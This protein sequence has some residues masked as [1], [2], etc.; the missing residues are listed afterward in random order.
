MDENNH[1]KEGKKPRLQ[2]SWSTSPAEI[3]KMWSREIDEL[4]MLSETQK[5][6]RCSRVVKIFLVAVNIFILAGACAILG[7][8]IWTHEVEY[9]SK[10]L[11][12]LI[13]VPLY[14]VDSVLMIVAGSS[15][16]LFTIVGLAGI[17]LPQKC[18]LGLHLSVIS[19]LAFILFAGG[20]LGYVFVGELEDSVRG[21][22]LQSVKENYGLPGKESI[23]TSWD[24]V[25]KNFECCGAYGDENSTTSWY[26]YKKESFWFKDGYNNGSFVPLSCCDKKNQ[27][28]CTGR[29]NITE[30]WP[31][32]SPP[33][34]VEVPT[35]Y[36]L[37]MKGCYDQLE[38]YLTQ[39]G[40]LIGTAAV[41]VGV[42][43]IIEIVMTI[44]Y[45]RSLR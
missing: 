32:R 24:S 30:S 2:V 11:A 8:G 27:E 4:G 39:N 22:L 18:L 28:V 15:I 38:G 16:L 40:I 6:V 44:F 35:N 41:V 14:Q 33:P 20:I 12:G 26:I 31:P 19:F 45:Y 3:K 43:M 1:G 10:Q 25:Q 36:T 37:Y 42:F 7:I 5:G 17:L 21:S 9:G 34:V 23:T 29:I 13:G